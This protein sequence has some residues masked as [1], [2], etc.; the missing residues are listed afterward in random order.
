LTRTRLAS[1]C[2]QK[3]KDLGKRE[4]QSI[5][6]DINTQHINIRTKQN[7][8]KEDQ[9][10]RQQ[11]QKTGPNGKRLSIVK[12]RNSNTSTN[13]IIRSMTSG[14]RTGDL[15]EESIAEL[16]VLVMAEQGRGVPDGAIESRAFS[17]GDSKAMERI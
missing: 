16:D 3:A 11:E 15:E 10:V 7:T 17:R 12:I 6:S 8:T 9:L 4:E 14:A 5:D 1:T 2:F 13:I